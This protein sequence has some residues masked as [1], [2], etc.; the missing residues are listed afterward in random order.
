MDKQSVACP[1]DGVFFNYEK[2]WGIGGPVVRTLLLLPRVQ[3]QSLLQDLGSYKSGG[4]ARKKQKKK[5]W[6]IDIYYNM[7][8]LWKHI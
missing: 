3:A 4:M 5:E 2:E 1:Y 7:D 6:N 8:E